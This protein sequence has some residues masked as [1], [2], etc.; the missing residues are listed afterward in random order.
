MNAVAAVW[1]RDVLRTLRNKAVMVSALLIP[2]LFLLAFH[3]AFSRSAADLGID[4]ADYLLPTAM[5]QAII[6]TAGGSALAVARDAEEGIHSRLRTMPAPMWAVAAGRV[7]A[8]LTR[9]A[10][11]GGIVLALSLALGARIRGGIGGILV[12]LLIFALV[13]AIIA[14][15][16]D[17]LCLLSAKPVSTAL[18]FQSLTIIILMFSTAFV[19]AEAL[20]DALAP[21]IRHVPVSPILE[22]IRA[23]MAGDPAGAA[24][25]E[26]AAWLVALAG[27]AGWG[28][29]HALSRRSHA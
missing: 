26:A 27:A 14:A 4:Y 5:M 1:R 22:T 17:G 25:V 20:P 9:M 18:L 28:F 2:G 10:W 19:P 15:G 11:S 23:R 13:T 6:F 12:M 29:V 16:V 3:A 8:D 7:L 21:V 24:G